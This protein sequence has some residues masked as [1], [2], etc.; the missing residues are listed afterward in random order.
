QQ[1]LEYLDKHSKNADFTRGAG[2]LLATEPYQA[3]TSYDRHA[4][5][6]LVSR[7]VKSQSKFVQRKSGVDHA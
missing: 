7:W 4:L 3:A 1:W 6:E 2:R 5:F